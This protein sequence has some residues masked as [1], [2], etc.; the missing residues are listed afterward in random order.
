MDAKQN[1]KDYM[2]VLFPGFSWHNMKK[3]A[4]QNMIPR[5]GGT[6][7]LETGERCC[8]CRS[9]KPLFGNV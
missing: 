2:P 1:G 9:R 6:F 3:D 7:L 5:L 4:P 8:R